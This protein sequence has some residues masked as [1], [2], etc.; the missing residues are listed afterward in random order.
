MYTTD[1]YSVNFINTKCFNSHIFIYFLVP[2]TYIITYKS[3]DCVITYKQLDQNFQHI[4]LKCAN[5]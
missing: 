4:I 1:E 3:E 2:N 5:I